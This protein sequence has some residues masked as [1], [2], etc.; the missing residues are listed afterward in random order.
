MPS[1]QH[2]RL[3]LHLRVLKGWRPSHCPLVRII[4]DLFVSL[5]SPDIITVPLRAARKCVTNCENHTDSMSATRLSTGKSSRGQLIT[6]TASWGS[7]YENLKR[8]GTNQ[9]I[10][11]KSD[12]TRITLN[13]YWMS[14]MAKISIL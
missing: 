7:A 14:R 13:H 9:K 4:H 11:V 8:T 12:F 6:A 1:A 10:T 2:S 5:W 3:V